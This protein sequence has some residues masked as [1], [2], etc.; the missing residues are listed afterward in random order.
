MSVQLFHGKKAMNELVSHLAEVREEVH[1]VAKHGKDETQA[2]IEAVRATTH[3]H[4]IYGPD[5]L[6]RATVE[7][8]EVDSY[9][10]LEAPNAMAIEYGHDPSGYFAG[11]ETKPPEGLYVLT[12]AA[13]IVGG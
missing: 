11:T 3:W 8:H 9:F 10:N 2:N 12:T 5:H 6:T 1:K 4:K 7:Q 13:L